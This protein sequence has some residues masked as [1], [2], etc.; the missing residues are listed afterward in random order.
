MG[1][2]VTKV[3]SSMFESGANSNEPNPMCYYDHK[4]M[5]HVSNYLGLN[6][7]GKNV[8]LY[9]IN[10]YKKKT[11]YTIFTYKKTTKG[12]IHNTSCVLSLNSQDIIMMH[13]FLYN[14]P[15]H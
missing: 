1:F 5:Q 9:E 7:W 2:K 4:K 6:L 13:L 3:K 15:L 14:Y 8:K 12:R 11:K 10:L